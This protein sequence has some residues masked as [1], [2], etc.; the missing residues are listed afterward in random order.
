MHVPVTDLV[1]FGSRLAL[2][3]V[4]AVAAAMSFRYARRR[5]GVSNDWLLPASGGVLLS[6][7]TILS[8]YDAI[9][10]MVLRPTEPIALA[11]W[12]WFLL[13]DLWMPVLAILLVV[14]RQQRDRAL[15]ALSTLSVTDQLTG[16]LNRRGF[17]ER[18]AITIA[19]SRR[20]GTPASLLMFDVDHFKAINDGYGHAAG[21]DVLRKLCATLLA[22]LRPGDLLGRFG[23][24]EFVVFLHANTQSAAAGTAQR[25]RAEIRATVPHP[26]GADRFVT[27]S[28]GVAAVRPGFEPEAALSLAITAAD[29]AMYVAKREGRDRVEIAADI[30]VAE[31][32]VAPTAG[33]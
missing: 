12:L 19:Q 9:D 3:F 21:D 5:R 17:F 22:G 32:G 23:G 15:A 16:A 14:T 1:Y 33:A 13:V 30:E 20:T 6:A 10:N 26:A 8:T 27:V 25:L 11:S 18:A 7:A 24:E 2:S 4:A 31:A 28:G 29:K